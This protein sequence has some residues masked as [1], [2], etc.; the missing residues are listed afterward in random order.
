MFVGT[1]VFI[2]T[3]FYARMLPSFSFAECTCC[4]LFP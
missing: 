3:N 2:G 4:Y 1:L